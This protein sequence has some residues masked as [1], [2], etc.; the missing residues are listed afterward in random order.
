MGLFD[1]FNR[2]RN[3]YQFTRSFTYFLPSPP[4]RKQGFQEKEF[5]QVFR[6]LIDSGYSLIDFKMQ[7]VQ[8]HETS[9]VWLCC[10]LGT[11]NKGLADKEI[12]LDYKQLSNSLQKNKNLD[13]EIQH[14]N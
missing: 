1:Y 6:F 12:D 13:F 9:G 3:E 2:Q 10:I 5:D 8:S 14:E 11:N 4:T 7:S